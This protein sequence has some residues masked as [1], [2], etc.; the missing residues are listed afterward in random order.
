VHEI[1]LL[2]ISCDVL[3]LCTPPK[4]NND[5]GICQGI[6]AQFVP[7]MRVL[8]WL[9]EEG[10]LR[11]LPNGFHQ[12]APHPLDEL[13]RRIEHNGAASPAKPII[14]PYAP[15]A[16]RRWKRSPPRSARQ[17]KPTTAGR[18]IRGPRE[19]LI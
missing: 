7:T 15:P 9:L 2:N 1:E 4:I 16:D 13:V 18:S 6:G 19:I 14:D 11:R 17:V 12:A 8:K 5:T 10:L 3:V